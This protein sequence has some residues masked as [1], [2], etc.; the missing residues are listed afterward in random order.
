MNVEEAGGCPVHAG[1]F[2]HPTEGGS[3]R[4]WWPN[5]L[6]LKILRKHA[7]AANPMDDDFDY[8]KEFL[9]TAAAARVPACSASRR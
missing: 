6:N 3:N 7:P 9:S 8:A 1:R 5:Q 4:E 2:G